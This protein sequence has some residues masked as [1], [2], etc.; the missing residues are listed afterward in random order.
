VKVEDAGG[1]VVTSDNSTAVTLA[2]GNN[3]GSAT[4]TGTLT[5]PAINGTATFNATTGPKGFVIISFVAGAT[6][7]QTP[8]QLPATQPTTATLAARTAAPVV[9]ASMPSTGAGG[10]AE[11]PV[12]A[13]AALATALLLA[14][15]A[16]AGA[17]RFFARL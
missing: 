7:A 5:Q 8:A 13:P 9:P 6:V 1:N 2:I 14:A 10:M 3:P 4:L 16:V 11:T 15:S 12:S 17:R